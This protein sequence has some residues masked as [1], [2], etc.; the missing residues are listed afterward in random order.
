MTDVAREA[1]VSVSTASAVL[2]RKAHCY[3]AASTKQQVFDAAK[4]VGYRPNLLAR[5]LRGEQ[6]NM[7]GLVMYGLDRGAVPNAKLQSIED[8]AWHHGYRL[9]I[10]THK[11]ERARLE[12]YIDEF[13]DRAVDGLIFW[14]M[15][16]EDGDLVEQALAG[17]TAVVTMEASRSFPAPDV[18]IDRERGARLQVEHLL[19]IGRRR[20]AFLLTSHHGHLGQAKVRGLEGALADHGLSLSQFP[21]LEMPRPHGVAAAG[22]QLTEQLLREGHDFDSIVTLSDDVA[23]P[24]IATLLRHG[25]RVPEDVAVVGFDDEHAPEGMVVPL[26]TISQP[27]DIGPIIF[28]QLLKNIR[29]EN[30]DETAP[31]RIR[32]APSLIIRESTVPGAGVGRSASDNE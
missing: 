19:Q 1:G 5:G 8:A 22:A 25:R 16:P 6:T 27:R 13:L 4:R 30:Q 2:G 28:E 26:T 24:A 15:L 29:A 9:L 23:L 10:G 7:I 14:P 32:L 17:G 18:A 11:D 20:P 3:A 12:A 31:A 21:V